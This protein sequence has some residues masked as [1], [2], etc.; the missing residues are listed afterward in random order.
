MRF[1]SALVSAV[2]LA[3]ALGFAAARPMAA[4]DSLT[5]ATLSSRADMVSGGRRTCR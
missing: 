1:L 3:L 4:T 5:V 2:V